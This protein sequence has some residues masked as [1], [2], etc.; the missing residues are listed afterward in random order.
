MTTKRKPPQMLQ[1]QTQD[2]ASHTPGLWEENIHADLLLPDG[3]FWS[4]EKA[5]NKGPYDRWTAVS[6]CDEEGPTDVVA[7]CHQDNAALISAAPEL[8][9]ALKLCWQATGLT[10]TSIRA[11]NRAARAAIAKAEARL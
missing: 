2:K 9:A 1:T 6:M 7:Y 4:F 5:T 3:N 10:V 8:L 11:A